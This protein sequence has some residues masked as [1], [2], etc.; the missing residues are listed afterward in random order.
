[1]AK[2]DEEKMMRCKGRGLLIVSVAVLIVLGMM[3]SA[4]ILAKGLYIDLMP[5]PDNWAANMAAWG[6]QQD[7]IST[8]ATVTQNVA[9]DLLTVDLHVQTDASTAQAAIAENAAVS[10]D[11][12][13]KLNALGLSNG[14]IQTVSYNVAPITNTSYMCDANNGPCSYTSVTTGYEATNSLELQV[15]DLS[16]G[17]S[18][19]DA[20]SSAGTNETFV[21]S[22]SFTLQDGTREAIES[23]M[24]QNAS[25]LTKAKAQSM[26]AGV[27]GTLGKAV[28]VSE[29]NFYYPQ[30]YLSNSMAMGSVAA[31]PA[32][33]TTLSPG[34]VEV[35]VTVDASYQIH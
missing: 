8:S 21:D 2:E 15:R 33:S 24:L 34:Q 18:V 7:L 22:I 13:G 12:L 11:L 19:I 27:G 4:Y 16:K 20:V 31:A 29:S 10:A 32:M 28:S 23:R 1:M 6:S 5:N 26:A 25:A 9:P 35:S 17:G 14:D 3:G 30:P